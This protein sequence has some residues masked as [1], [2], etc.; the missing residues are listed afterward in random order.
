LTIGKAKLCQKHAVPVD[1]F[2]RCCGARAM[3]DT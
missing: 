3:V 2:A 1:N